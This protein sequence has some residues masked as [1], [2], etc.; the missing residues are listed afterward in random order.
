M[1]WSIAILLTLTVFAGC[2]E[3]GDPVDDTDPQPPEAPY[4]RPVMPE[5]PMPEGPGH[6]HTDPGQHKFLWNYEFGSRDPLMQNQAQ[7]AGL[8]ALDLQ[9]DHLFGAIYGANTVSV[10]G[11]LAIWDLVDPASPSLVGQVNIPGAIGGDRSLEVTPDGAFA[12][13]GAERVSCFGQVNPV[14]LNVYLFD[15][16]DKTR[17][18]VAD[19]VTVAGPSAGSPDRLSPSQA[20]IF[21]EHSIAVHRI[22]GT[23][24]AFVHGKIF[25]IAR[26]EVTGARLVDTGQAI[27]VG[28]DLYLRDTPWGGVWALTA[29]G[30]GG[31]QIF[32]VS[33]PLNP[34]EIGNWDLP[35]RASLDE[36]YY[37]HTADVGFFDDQ[38]I[39]I[40]SSEDWL[41]W[42]SPMWILDATPLQGFVDGEPFLLDWIGT[43]QNPGNHTALGTSFSLHNPRFHA[44]GILTLSSYHGGLW[45]LDFRRAEQ[46]ATPHEIAYVAFA[47]GDQTLAQD[48]VHQTIESTLCQLG[49]TLD[50]PTYMDVERGPQ[51]HLYAADVYMGLYA[52]AP[53]AGHPVYGTGDSDNA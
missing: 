26:D 47:S 30:G 40:V 42:P 32:D 33:D 10:N 9:A 29:N 18:L 14:P 11:G 51:G 36:E 52:F 3:S 24:Y 21:G 46:R 31:L 39:V 20:A 44:D 13:M 28:H 23:D 17:P 43:W 7:I 1:K 8:H 38:I 6:D 5:D 48:P 12:V 16:R 49:L 22:D 15:T 50:A 35:E 37:F 45:Q 2:I 53:A 19:V 25:E 4:R 41:D 34:L 27:N